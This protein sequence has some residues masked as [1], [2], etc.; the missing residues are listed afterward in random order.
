MVT[1]DGQC[2]LQLYWSWP[3]LFPNYA[4]QC[5]CTHLSP[6]SS[7]RELHLL[8][9]LNITISLKFILL[10]FRFWLLLLLFAVFLVCSRHPFVIL[11]NEKAS[12]VWGRYYSYS[13]KIRSSW[14]DYRLCIISVCWCDLLCVNCLIHG[15]LAMYFL[16]YSYQQLWLN[17]SWRPLSYFKI[18]LLC[19]LLWLFNI[20]KTLEKRE[21]QKKD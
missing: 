10:R 2:L 4:V 6:W 14:L 8:S 9:K 7:L 15:H 20:I 18:P 21:V 12:S 11:L 1:K 17:V 5:V 19:F 13:W 3:Y 16:I